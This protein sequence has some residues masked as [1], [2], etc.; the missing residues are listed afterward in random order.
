LVRYYDE[1]KRCEKVE[2]NEYSGLVG[3]EYIEIRS[4]PNIGFP[5]NLSDIDN[6]V[7]FFGF[8]DTL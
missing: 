6:D 7:R 1:S 8:N 4:M 3:E 2:T 5:Y